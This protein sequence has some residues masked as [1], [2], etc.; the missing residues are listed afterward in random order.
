MRIGL[1]SDT[2]PPFTDGVSTSV[3]MLKSG[4]EKLGHI[5]FVVT[6]NPE[7]F[8]YKEE[9]NI[10]RIP[11]IKTGI[12]Q[13]RLTGIYPIKAQA[14]IK[15]WNLDIIH[16]HTEFG[17]GTFARIVSGKLDI[18]LVHTYHTM[19][20]EYV[21]YITKGHF[22]KT[23]KKITQYL[24][25]F[26][27][28]R[29]VKELIVPTKKT[30]DLFKEK[31]NI[32]R[33][34]HII[35]TGIDVERFHYENIDKKDVEAVKKELGITKKDFVL[36]FIG[37]LGKEKNIDFIL[38]NFKDLKKKISNL[39]F[40]IVGAGPHLNELKN[41][42]E[43]EDITSDIIFT[44]RVMYAQI[45]IYSQISDIFVTASTT[46]TQGLTVIEAMAAGK[47]VVCANDESFKLVITDNQDGLFFSNKE[48]YIQNILKIYNNKEFRNKIS[49][50]AI[51]T[52]NRFGLDAYAK[53]ALEVYKIA[54]LS[55]NPKKLIAKIIKIF[56][57]K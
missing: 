18:P 11:G 48:E 44:G 4:L 27:C 1:F 34:V 33:N 56:I 14:I 51:I 24:T 49:T 30:Y 13:Y 21:H 43:E 53:S 42:I 37:R 15:K 2:F 46:E 41:I 31:Y 20:E 54:I 57:R 19:Y 29:T 25:M 47:P 39:K 52:S 9:D 38:K 3:L 55:Y 16:T 45:P 12:Y 36:L 17:I 6:V 35:P 5:V 22:E 40:V 7:S 28:D 23:S 8:K 10:L 32:E 26:Y 50:Q